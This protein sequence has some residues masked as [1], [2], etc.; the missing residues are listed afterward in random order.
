MA[1]PVGSKNVKWDKAELE[2]LYWQE[3]LSSTQIAQR[4]GVTGSAVRRA[5]SKLGIKIRTLSEAL[6]G[7]RH[8]KWRGGKSKTS[9]GYIEVYMPNHPRA[10]KRGRVYEHL[11]VWEATHGRKLRKGEIVH[12]LNGIKTDNRP[13]NL[14]ALKKKTHDRFI[15]IL[16]ERIRYLEN[17]LVRCSQQVMELNV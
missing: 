12:H 4:I 9:T 1:R 7:D 5:M 11:L 15:P 6:S 3:G 13:E 2:K 14:I 8:Y 17:E 10:N 16:R